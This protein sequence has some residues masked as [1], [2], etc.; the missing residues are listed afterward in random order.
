M[1]SSK[2]EGF[3]LAILEAMS[4]GLPVI[5]SDTKYGPADLLGNQKYGLLYPVGNVKKLSEEIRLLL[6]DSRLAKEY[7][8]LG[9]RRSFDYDMPKIVKKYRD[10]FSSL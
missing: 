1:F 2:Y 4:L 10:F 9:I 3:G 6:T 7:S 5:S 8:T